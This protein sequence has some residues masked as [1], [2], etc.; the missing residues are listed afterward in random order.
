MQAK[1]TCEGYNGDKAVMDL[2]KKENPE[3]P[4]AID[5]QIRK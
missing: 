4:F 1:W 2:Y 5:N 3:V